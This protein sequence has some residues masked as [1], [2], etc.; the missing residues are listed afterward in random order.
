M[1]RGG[2]SHRDEALRG[3]TAQALN[4]KRTGKKYLPTCSHGYKTT[5]E[6]P[7]VLKNVRYFVEFFVAY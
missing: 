2:A 3:S 4:R 7:F 6:R 5:F 1:K